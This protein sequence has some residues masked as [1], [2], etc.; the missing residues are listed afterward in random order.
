MRI[1]KEGAEIRI[2]EQ[3]LIL[4]VKRG[5]QNRGAFALFALKTRIRAAILV[6]GGRVQCLN[7]NTLGAVVCQDIIDK[8]L[9]THSRIVHLVFTAMLDAARE[10]QAVAALGQIRVGI[11][12]GAEVEARIGDAVL[13]QIGTRHFQAVFLAVVIVVAG[14]ALDAVSATVHSVAVGD[15]GLVAGRRRQVVHVQRI[16][17]SAFL[18]GRVAAQTAQRTGSLDKV[19]DLRK[20][21]DY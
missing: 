19:C 13:E 8:A 15:R 12:F 5:T 21:R 3:G 20:S 11:A 4:R 7:R 2:M 9:E 18:S 17:D 6:H 16:A 14:D 10:G 1:P